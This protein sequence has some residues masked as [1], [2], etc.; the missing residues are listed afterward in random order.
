MRVRTST[1][2][3]RPAS[4]GVWPSPL[5]WK[6]TG[7]HGLGGTWKASL[8]PYCQSLCEPGPW[9]CR[10]GWWT[11]GGYISWRPDTLE[12]IVDGIE[13]KGTKG[14]GRTCRA[15]AL[16]RAAGAWLAHPRQAL[17][18]LGPCS[19]LL[20]PAVNWWGTV[21]PGPRF[22]ATT[23]TVTMT[24][25]R[26]RRTFA[27]SQSHQRLKTKKKSYGKRKPLRARALSP[28]RWRGTIVTRRRTMWRLPAATSGIRTHL[29][30]ASRKIGSSLHHAHYLQE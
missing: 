15:T 17:P 1:W 29:L 18:S 28:Q 16:H 4:D 22:T 14:P 23:A 20:L 24:M 25:T 26:R 19:G 6:S 2:K 3:S 7:W 13:H 8:R 11:D 12:L 10:G 5:C 27:Q 30:T 21:I 9:H